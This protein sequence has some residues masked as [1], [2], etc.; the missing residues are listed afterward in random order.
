MSMFWPKENPGYY[1][2]SK[3][4][5]ESI[6]GWVDAG[7]Y[8]GSER[9]GEEGENKKEQQ[10]GKGDEM[11]MEMEDSLG[12]EGPVFVNEANVWRD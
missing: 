6:V 10:D 4:A 11:E 3:R 8:E 5:K 1:R 9:V 7:W 12:G 2:M